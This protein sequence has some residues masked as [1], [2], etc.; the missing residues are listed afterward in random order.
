MIT[1]GGER[2]LVKQSNFALL[3][4]ASYKESIEGY[5]FVHLYKKVTLNFKKQQQVI[6]LIL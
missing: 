5:N 1:E 3:V 4:C 6:Y 2:F